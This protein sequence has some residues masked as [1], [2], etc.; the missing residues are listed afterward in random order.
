MKIHDFERR[1]TYKLNK[2]NELFS[3]M[4]LKQMLE[5]FL[6]VSSIKYIK[7][8][9]DNHLLFHPTLTSYTS[10]QLLP[11][12]DLLTFRQSDP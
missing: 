7:T 3:D 12:S 2:L 1:K 10:Y 11:L 9:W 8:L 5:F 4:K 6:F